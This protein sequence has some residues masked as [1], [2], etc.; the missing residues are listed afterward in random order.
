M[1]YWFTIVL[2][3]MIVACSLSE[4][5]HELKPQG[6]ADSIRLRVRFGTE[7]PKQEITDEIQISRLTHFINALP[8]KWS[9]PWYGPPVGTIYF[10]FYHSGRFI[11]NFYV[12]PDFFGRDAGNNFC[13]Q[14]ATSQ[15]LDVLSAIVGFDIRSHLK[16]AEQGAAANP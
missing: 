6:E 15:Q 8:D 4:D 14:P 3:S 13:S 5:S 7:L 9:V 1:K 2:L 12:G 10:D 11:G 16:K